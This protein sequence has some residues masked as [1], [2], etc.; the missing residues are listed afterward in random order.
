MLVRHPPPARPG[1]RRIIS[2]AHGAGWKLAVASTSA[3]A[4]VQRVVETVA[5]DLADE[6]LVLAGD[7]VPDKK[8]DPAIYELAIE[9]LGVLKPEAI[10]IE[11][12]RNGLLAAQAAGLT[13]VVTVSGY[14]VHEDF[15]TAPL[16]VSSLGDAAEPM[17]VIANRT[18]LSPRGQLTLEDLEALLRER[19]DTELAR[20]GR[21]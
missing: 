7:V 5:G 19:G 12:S 1:V 16:V 6:L 20:D 13:C 14:S 2:A 10:V 3:E 15:S 11:D 17:T 21:R 9:R 8:P 4:S 18:A